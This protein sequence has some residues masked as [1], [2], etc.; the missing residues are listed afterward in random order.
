[1]PSL[2]TQ[3]LM[4]VVRPMRSDGAGHWLVATVNPDYFANQYSLLL[5]DTPLRASLLSYGGQLLVPAEG[6]RR[7]TGESMRALP[8]FAQE[9]AAGRE[10]GQLRGP[11]LEDDEVFTAFRSARRQPVVVVVETPSTVVT[12]D[13]QAVAIN[14]GGGTA[15]A[16]LLLGGLSAM[17]WR[18]L[19]GHESVSTD[20]QR[21]QGHLA[22]QDAFTDQLFQLSPIPMVV[23]DAQGRFLRVNQSWVDFTGLSAEQAIGNNL[24][25]LYPAQLAAPHEVQEQ[26]AIASGQAVSYEEQVLDRDGL[27]RDVMVRVTPFNGPDGAV[28]GVIGCLMDVTEFRE[29]A[30]HTLAAKDA[31]ERSNAAKSEFLANISHE[32]RTPLQSLQGFAELGTNRAN[33]Q[34][35]LQGMINTIHG[36]GQR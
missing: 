33:A 10:H 30:Q 35:R 4:P 7:L 26:M 23:K 11:G 27:P 32:L 15:L 25:R 14:L 24:G 22:A 8:L 2:A 12:A 21:A 36:A 13:V 17:A 19:R 20:L 18:S 5:T 28:A 31:A 9:L 1:L 34:P 16:L 29:A 6:S 3:H